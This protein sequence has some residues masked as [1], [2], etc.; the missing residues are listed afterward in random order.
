MIVKMIM[1][2]ATDGGSGIIVCF[3]IRRYLPRDHIR[4]KANILTAEEAVDLPEGRPVLII[5]APGITKELVDVSGAI[6]RFLE[7]LEIVQFLHN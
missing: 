2:P 7:V 3:N 6:R 4:T 5:S 1:T